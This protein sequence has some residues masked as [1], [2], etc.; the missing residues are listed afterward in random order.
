[1]S[2]STP[3]PVSAA[4][5]SVR[6]E[7]AA[8]SRQLALVAEDGRILWATSQAARLRRLKSGQPL[9]GEAR[10][11]TRLAQLH[12]D[13]ISALEQDVR[14]ELLYMHAL[15]REEL[16]ESE[17]RAALEAAG[18]SRRLLVGAA[19]QR[20]QLL[21]V[22]G[23]EEAGIRLVPHPA[24][25]PAGG[26]GSGSGHSVAVPVRSAPV[27]A[28]AQAAVITERWTVTNPTLDAAL[29]SALESQADGDR[30]IEGYMA[31][32][33]DCIERF[34]VAGT[35]CGTEAAQASTAGGPP[36]QRRVRGQLGQN[37]QAHCA[38]LVLRAP[39][40][41]LSGAPHACL[42][43]CLSQCAS[44]AT[45]A[46][47]DLDDRGSD[48]ASGTA[49]G[50][51]VRCGVVLHQG[52]APPT[53]RPGVVVISGSTDL[54][55]V[56]YVALAPL[57]VVMFVQEECRLLQTSPLTLASSELG[58]QLVAVDNHHA[59]QSNIGTPMGTVAT[60]N[61][62]PKS[63]SKN[64]HANGSGSGGSS[65]RVGSARAGSSGSRRRVEASGGNSSTRDCNPNTNVGAS[66]RSEGASSEDSPR[67]CTEETRAT[68]DT[69][70]AARAARA[71]FTA[72]RANQAAAGISP[73]ALPHCV[74]VADL[75]GAGHAHDTGGNDGSLYTS[76]FTSS[77][78]AGAGA[79]ASASLS[80]AED[81]AA[82]APVTRGGWRV[83]GT[84]AGAGAGRG[85]GTGSVVSTGDGASKML[86]VTSG[87]WRQ[88]EMRLQQA[89]RAAEAVSARGS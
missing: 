41:V 7:R 34:L 87:R 13:Q 86:R 46:A 49:V 51:A 57:E 68:V 10:E 32:P 56:E 40:I 6:R 21:A 72:L 37:R 80:A 73:E 35:L 43:A 55:S 58:S 24:P 83:P 47:T 81:P 23:E 31:I 26:P 42:A 61:R 30:H 69:A 44:C 77:A 17:R 52:H 65:T 5:A 48:L 88:A 11:A 14:G 2:T 60:S 38:E 50:Y 84:G 89:I 59:D 74:L 27:T 71:E 1:M 62:A 66:A 79:G 45:G 19:R 12:S 9:E 82:A 64:K 29:A 8:L 70:A 25:H 22:F 16:E 39:E 36:S 53:H 76:T 20:L 67:G 18:C 33:P 78:G 28:S 54:G 3:S 63:K 15:L 4:L 75:L 85:K